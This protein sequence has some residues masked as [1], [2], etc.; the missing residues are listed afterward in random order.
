MLLA[1][2]GRSIRSQF[3]TDKITKNIEN[4]SLN[5]KPPPG[6]S[7]KDHIVKILYDELVK[8]GLVTDGMLPKLQ[9][10]FEALQH[11]VSRVYIGQPSMLSGDSNNYTTLT[12]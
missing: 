8:S 1:T 11:Q 6:L 2:Y 10:C 7:R 12:L 5:E 9:N 3:P 4:R